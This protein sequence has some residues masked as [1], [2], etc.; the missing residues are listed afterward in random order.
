MS[1]KYDKLKTG[2]LTTAPGAVR[3]PARAALA[4]AEKAARRLANRL[5]TAYPTRRVHQGQDRESARCRH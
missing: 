5:R 1:Q 2:A 3:F 4:A